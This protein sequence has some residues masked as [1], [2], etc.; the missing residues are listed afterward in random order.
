M[1]K[2]KFDFLNS[3]SSPILNATRD[4]ILAMS[5]TKTEIQNFSTFHNR[6][7]NSKLFV[8]FINMWN[9][10]IFFICYEILKYF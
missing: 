9:K 3:H 1:H 2:Q 6:C 8:H 4:S 5:K 10:G 7:H